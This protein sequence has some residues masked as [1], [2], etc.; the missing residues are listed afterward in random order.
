VWT[1]P[2]PSIPSNGCW[3]R[4]GFGPVDLAASKLHLPFRAEG[5]NNF[6]FRVA[7]GEL[8]VTYILIGG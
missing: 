6:F 3:L 2:T 5:Y 8:A 1:G 7:P 4:L